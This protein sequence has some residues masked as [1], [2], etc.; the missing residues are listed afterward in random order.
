MKKIAVAVGVMVT[1]FCL[2]AMEEIDIETADPL[3]MEILKKTMDNSALIDTLIS[4]ID[5]KSRLNDSQRETLKQRLVELPQDDYEKVTVGVLKTRAG[6]KNSIELIGV[7]YALTDQ[8]K[9]NNVQ[10][11]QQHELAEKE[12]TFKVRKWQWGVLISVGTFVLTNGGQLVGN[13]SQ[14][15]S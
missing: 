12:Y 4:N 6:H 13:L 1:V 5:P 7:L 15:F 8:L 14:A 9:E 3:T 10:L 2:G 11:Q